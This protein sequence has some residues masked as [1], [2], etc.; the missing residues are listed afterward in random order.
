M[1][2]YQNPA[3]GKT[4]ISPRL[5]A[6]GAPERKVRIATKAIE[7]SE[8][9]A[10]AQIKGEVVLRH[11]PDAKSSI[12]AKFFEDD[13]GIFVL[14][15]QGYTVATSKP[16]NASFSFIGD[17]IEKLV[18]FIN[19]I[20]A[21]P[22]GNG[23]P[24]RVTDQELRH[25]VL[26][27]V[28]VQA[29]VRDN[30]DLFR[31]VLRAA[32]TKE[33]VIAVG[34]RK[35]QLTTFERLIEDE[36]FFASMKSKKGCGDEALWQMFFEKNPWIFGYGL[37]YVYLSGLDEKKLEQA[38]SGY[39]VFQRGK[40]VDA[41]LRS[42]GVISS[43][44]FVEIKTHRTPLLETQAYRSGC[45]AASRELSGAVSQVQGTVST[46]TE[47]V[48]KLSAKDDAGNPTGDDMYQYSPK[49]FVV[50]GSLTEFVTPNGVNEDR[51]R[52]F[53]L[54]RRNTST[55]EIITFDE[56]YERAR[57]IVHQHEAMAG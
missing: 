28:Q 13:R 48:R 19:H 18:E 32:L 40:R 5:D 56:L 10:F 17:E 33:D 51:H 23:G 38:V 14:S 44:C 7:H 4:Y 16:R 37:S 34:Y 25:L 26:S 31:E 43:L 21:M 29:L 8:S 45:W 46:A 6:F 54:F 55:P 11:K 49:A 20:Q 41:L 39:S 52:S 27:K 57:F 2:S 35:K 1:D 15:I 9:Y 53:E 12:T 47:S 42:R 3:P 36:H 50:A 30:D 22:L 24:L